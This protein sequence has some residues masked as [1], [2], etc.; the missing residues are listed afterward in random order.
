MKEQAGTRLIITSEIKTMDDASGYIVRVTKKRKTK[1]IT[2]PTLT[3]DKIAALQSLCIRNNLTLLTRKLRKHADS[4]STGVSNP[5]S[6]SVTKISA[7]TCI[8]KRIYTRL[9]CTSAATGSG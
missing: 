2:I 4:P 9:N 5:L 1:S 8:F 7:R 6:S 3:I